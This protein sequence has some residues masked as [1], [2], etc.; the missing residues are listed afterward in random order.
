MAPPKYKDIA[1]VKCIIDFRIA[2]YHMIGK[3]SSLYRE[4]AI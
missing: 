4:A 3:N 2:Y 1:A